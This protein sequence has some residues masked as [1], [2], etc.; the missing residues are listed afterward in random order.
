MSWSSRSSAPR[1]RSFRSYERYVAIL[2]WLTLS[3]FAYVA[4]ALVVHVPWG[5]VA[6]DTF[7]P[8]RH[9]G[10]R[11]TS[12]LIVAVLGTTISPYLF[13]WQ[14]SEEAEDERD[15]SA[16]QQP[17]IGGAERGAAQSS[18]ASASTPMS[19]WAFPTSSACSSSSPPRRRCTRTAITDIQ[20]S[21]QAAEALRPIAGPFRFRVFALGIIG[22]G[23]LAV[24]VLAGSAA[25][26][27]RRGAAAGR[28]ASAA[29]RATPRR[30]YATIAVGDADRHRHQFRR[31]SI[32]S[33]RCSGAR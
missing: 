24:P 31:L 17:L 7:V 4:T 16:A 26:A 29:C 28:P 15:Q 5:E 1:S 18:A 30:F 22:T 32:R 20:T 25:Y 8:S 14:A 11:T 3:L 23:L 12:S 9:A 19:A 2:K 33:R 13:F 27:A 10:A 6:Y 21:A